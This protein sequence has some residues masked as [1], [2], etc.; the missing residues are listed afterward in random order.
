MATHKLCQHC[1]D[2]N[3]KM[4]P[5]QAATEQTDRQALLIETI[6]LDAY[7]YT[8]TPSSS[9]RRQE[10]C[11]KAARSLQSTGC[12]YVRD[13]RVLHA[14]NEAFL[15]LLERY[16]ASSDGIRD[17]RPELHYQVGVTPAMSEWPRNNCSRA[18]A[19]PPAHRPVTLCPPEAD[20]KWRYFWRVGPLPPTP[21]RFP[22]LNTAPVIPPDFP[23][24]SQIMDMWGRKM[25]AAVSGVAAALAEGFG[26][27]ADAFTKRMEYGPH[28]LAPTGSNFGGRFGKV[29]TVLAGYH[30]D[31][32]FLTIHGKSRFPGLFVWLR[33]GRK[34]A[35]K[36]PE[37]CLLVQAGKQC[38]YLTGGRILAGFHEVVVAPETR[39]V[40]ERR[41][42]EGASLWRVSSTL[43]SH[44]AS[45]EVLRPLLKKEEGEES[46]GERED[47]EKS[48]YPLAGEQVLSELRAIKLGR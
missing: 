28:L 45:D 4:M 9:S 33:D 30:Y 3:R 5:S 14:D 1:L 38:E 29:G 36:V 7:F 10:E 26:L 16:F 42:K 35:V 2:Y 23:E 39:E 41:R 21:S 19:L 8:A 6:D 15:D 24:W 17:A 11:V 32:N 25:L 43:F 44:I 22:Q 40:I 37:G 46:E 48:E 13:S 12:L 27:P 20:P 31:L 47:G 34:V 18:A